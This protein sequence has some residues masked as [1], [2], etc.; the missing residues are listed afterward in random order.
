MAH[1]VD[2]PV[3]TTVSTAPFSVHSALALSESRDF[4]SSAAPSTHVEQAAESRTARQ[5]LDSIIAHLSADGGLCWRKRFD[6]VRVHYEEVIY[7]V[8]SVRYFDED[9]GKLHAVLPDLN[10]APV[11]LPHELDYREWRRDSLARALVRENADLTDYKLL[12]G[13]PKKKLAHML[14]QT[15][16][17]NVRAARRAARE[18]VT[19]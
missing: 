10:P 8:N 14:A 4:C 5:W 11:L 9:R 17:A 18:A 12:T 2:C 15:R 19:A 13:L 16:L 6:P 7:T 3:I 1:P